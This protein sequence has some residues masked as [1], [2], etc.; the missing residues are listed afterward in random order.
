MTDKTSG[1]PQPVHQIFDQGQHQLSEIAAR[2]HFLQKAAQQLQAVLP[3]RLHSQWAI[4]ALTREQL[5]V[6]TTSAAWGTL[7]RGHQSQ[8]LREAECVIGERPKQFKLRIVAP[9]A[10]TPQT[11][12]PAMSAETID[13]LETAA[14]GM[15]DPRLQDALNQLAARGRQQQRED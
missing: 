1:E 2:A 8:L 7:L 9:P 4:A 10:K 11:S 6:V 5:I 13:Y 14:S 15:I 12:A 3:D